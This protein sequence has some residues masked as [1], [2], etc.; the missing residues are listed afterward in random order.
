MKRVKTVLLGGLVTGS[1]FLSA[2][3]ARGH[4]VV[5]TPVYTPTERRQQIAR[6]WDYEFKQATD[7]W[8]HIL[9]LRPA[10]RLTIWN[11]R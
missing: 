7:D 2:L 5:L 3:L 1:L 6:N 11:V 4:D 10:S 8:D 9:L